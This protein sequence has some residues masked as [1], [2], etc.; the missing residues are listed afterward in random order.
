MS[1]VDVADVPAG[2]VAVVVAE[3]MLLIFFTPEQ[4]LNRWF[5]A[6]WLSRVQQASIN[7]RHGLTA[8]A[9]LTV[10]SGNDLSYSFFANWS[11]TIFNCKKELKSIKDRSQLTYTIC[12]NLDSSQN[13]IQQTYTDVVLCF[14]SNV[15]SGTTAKVV[16]FLHPRLKRLTK[17][18]HL[19]EG[20]YLFID[21]YF[22]NLS[23]ITG[24]SKR[25]FSLAD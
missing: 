12:N 23:L 3:Q 20:R 14:G 5:R 8:T 25:M 19:I 16:G 18:S 22:P 2:V 10:C 17:R 15:Q 21:Y 1:A 11:P 9:C 13:Q 4:Y 6:G 7:T 24:T